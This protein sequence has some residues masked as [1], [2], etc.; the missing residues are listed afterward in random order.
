MA[1]S[2]AACSGPQRVLDPAGPQAEHIARLATFLFVT[3]GI[4]CAIVFAAL[5]L[6]VQNGR[7]R[8]DRGE[9]PDETPDGE[10]R[11]GRA[12]GLA[13]AATTVVL[14][15]YLVAAVR[16]GRALAWTA[17]GGPTER[18]GPPGAPPGL[19]PERGPFPGGAPLTVEVT[20]RQWWW[21]MKYDDPTPS[22]MLTTANEL[23]IPVGRP[24]RIV[25][26]SYDVIHSFWVPK[27]HGKQDMIPGYK[28]VLW[29]RADRPGVYRGQCA[30]YC[31]HQH[32]HMAF[33]VIAESPA[34][35]ARWYES[36]LAPSAPPT[37]SS[38]QHGQTVFMSNACIMCHAIG[39]TPAASRVGPDLTHLASRRT[40]AAGTLPNTRG[41]LAGWIV[42]PQGI[43]PGARMPSNQ[44]T[45]DDLNALLDYLR[46]L[47]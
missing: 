29:L 14:F 39:G 19:P 5:A 1:A 26:Q 6:S 28:N 20:G 37:D 41:H 45:P 4:V 43:K 30:E 18:A 7:R 34:E 47:K 12:I 23:H 27:L 24:V 40:L 17:E 32:A 13:A 22:R 3:A 46:S 36:Q 21:E 42:D 9:A 11:R 31:G 38:A 15:V 33:D 8:A 25:T 44:L 16:T 2:V 10:R 35:F